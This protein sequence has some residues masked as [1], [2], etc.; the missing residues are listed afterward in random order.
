MAY[1]SQ[2]VGSQSSSIYERLTRTFGGP[3]YGAD[4]IDYAFLG[5]RIIALLSVNSVTLPAGNDVSQQIYRLF[6][7]VVRAPISLTYPE[8]KKWEVSRLIIHN[9]HKWVD[10][11]PRIEDPQ[12]ILTFLKHH[13]DLATKG[14]QSQDEPIRSALCLLVHASGPATEE[15][16]MSFDP[17]DP[18]FARGI[19]DVFQ[20]NKPPQLRKA[21]LLFLPLIADRWFDTPRPIMAPD[22]MRTFCANWASAV[23]AIKHTYD[24]QK[25]TLTVLFGMI[26]S[27]HW[28]PHVTVEKWT[29]LEY[30]TSVPEDSRSLRRCVENPELTDVIKNLTNSNVMVH[31][32]AILCWRYEELIPQVQEQL[33]TVVKEIVLG[34]GRTYLDVCLSVMDSG[35]KDAKDELQNTRVF[36]AGSPTAS[37]LRTKIDILE[38]VTVSLVT[39][40]GD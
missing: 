9:A 21:A 33:E 39:L 11:S 38:R 12:E 30:F 36:T 34:D 14:G 3:I 16:I 8:E 2:G 5:L 17:T 32:L 15:A 28:R 22:Q 18:L 10:F 1:Y 31:W 24:V 23:D 29:L 4:E 13:F 19:S 25:A 27:P 26:D 37:A 7:L 35:V 20:D 40:R 6:C